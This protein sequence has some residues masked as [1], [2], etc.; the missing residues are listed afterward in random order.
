[1]KETFLLLKVFVIHSYQTIFRRLVG[2][3]H[4]I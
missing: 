1:M 4:A 3:Y 2:R